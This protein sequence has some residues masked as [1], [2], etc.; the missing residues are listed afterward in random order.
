MHRMN[1]TRGNYMIIVNKAEFIKLMF[2][3]CANYINTLLKTKPIT[4]NTHK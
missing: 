2:R 3:L 4:E 1:Q